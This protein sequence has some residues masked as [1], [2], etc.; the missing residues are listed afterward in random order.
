TLGRIEGIAAKDPAFG[1]DA[2]WILPS[3]RA[4]AENLGYTV[5]DPA[6]VI[7]THVSHLVREHAPELLGHEEVQ[8]LLNALARTAPK[9]AEDLCPKTL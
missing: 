2:V 3:Q 9:L 1:L 6:T 4:Q 5:V 8:A 7:A